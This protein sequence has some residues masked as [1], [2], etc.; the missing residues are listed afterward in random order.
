MLK[1]YYTILCLL[2]LETA[3]YAQQ[4]PYQNVFTGA[5]FIWNPASTAPGM[6]LDWGLSY[7]Q[8]WLGFEGAPMTGSAHFQFPFVQNNM[9]AGIWAMRDETGPLSYYQTGLSYA[10]K[11]GIGNNGQLS[12]G[13]SILMNQFRFDGNQVPAV[14]IGDPLLL[15]QRVSSLSPNA[16]LGIFYVSNQDMYSLN[17]DAFFVGIGSQQ[18]LANKLNFEEANS[19]VA[20]TREIHANAIIGARFIKG[21]SFVEPSLWVDYAHKELLYARGQ[22][23]FEQED[24]FWAGGAIGSDYSISLQ[25]GLILNGF[26]GQGNL[27]IGGMGTYN[28]GV[29]GP[30]QGLGV[31]LMVVYRYWR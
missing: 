15:E 5:A 26:I 29:L 8:Q 14:D 9:S 13:L 19:S 25:A 30:Y 6:F 17:D 18:L 12:I 31:E 11:M 16:G 21:Y 3:I 22:V 23:L 20:L 2:L 27:R 4:L 10:Y 7:R 24:A 28:V 1:I